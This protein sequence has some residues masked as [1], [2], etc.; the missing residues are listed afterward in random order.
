MTVL[1]PIFAIILLGALCKRFNVLDHGFWPQAERATYYVFF[2]CLLF[3][4]LATAGFEDMPVLPMAG[5]MVTAV[6]AVAGLLLF[7]RP[8]LGLSGP[9]FSSVFQGAIRPN[10]YVGLAG[11]MTLAG[12]QGVTLT[13]I[14]ILSMVP[15]VNLLC[16]PVVAHFG[17]GQD[18]GFK[19]TLLEIVKNP[20]LVACAAGALAN[21]TDVWLP[22]PV[23]EIFAL[24]GRASLPMALLAVGAGLTFASLRANALAVGVSSL[25]KLALLP[26]AAGLA[27]TLYQV[28]LSSALVAVLFA[29]V[30]VS[31]SSYI[32]ARQ[33]GGDDGCMAAIITA[34]TVLAAATLP[35]ALSFFQ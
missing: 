3:N 16:V 28:P 22:P 21:A 8:W 18:A 1:I 35:V 29:A 25:A 31:A 9:A 12:A 32:L 7:A 5:A 26:A 30:P 6:L 23:F 17:A 4:N 34:Q 20:L 10:T 14:A 24:L 27:C 19:R 13:A 15:L 11:A 33:L 2:P